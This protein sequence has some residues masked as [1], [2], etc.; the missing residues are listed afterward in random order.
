MGGAGSTNGIVEHADFTPATLPSAA[1]YRGGVAFIT[2]GLGGGKD[3][4]SSELRAE[5]E[6][7]KAAIADLSSAS[8]YDDSEVVARIESLEGRPAGCQCAPLGPV[9]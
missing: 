5:V 3:N 1:T 8:G 9:S 6:R 2:G 7:L 4:S